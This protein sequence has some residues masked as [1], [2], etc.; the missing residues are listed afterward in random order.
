MHPR[1][2]SH[3]GAQYDIG[4]AR[5]QLGCRMQH[6]ICTGVQRSLQQWRREGV[7]HDEDRVGG[8][9][10]AQGGKVGYLDGRIRG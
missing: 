8:E 9:I 2:Q 7:V 5:E 4:M 1:R 3:D 6:D 10:L